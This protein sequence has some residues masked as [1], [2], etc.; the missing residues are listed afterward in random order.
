ME[1]RYGKC[2]NCGKNVLLTQKG[3]PNKHCHE[4]T[5]QEGSNISTIGKI[6]IITLAVFAIIAGTVFFQ[7]NPF[8]GIII[9]L[10]FLVLI[11]LMGDS[12]KL[13]TKE[14]REQMQ[15]NPL[16][17]FLCSG[18]GALLPDLLEPA[19]NPNHRKF[20]HSATCGFLS[21]KIISQI[22]LD[23]NVK[24][25]VKELISFG[26]L[27]YLSHLAADFTTPKGPP[28]LGADGD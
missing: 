15:Y 27:G 28:L 4:C 14:E 11:F 23:P 26:Y 22:L 19:D 18:L 12:F 2:P 9:A 21:S 7:I 5:P 20:F 16:R 10:A 17:A 24:P 13:V 3:K 6:L 25:E 1:G 8:L